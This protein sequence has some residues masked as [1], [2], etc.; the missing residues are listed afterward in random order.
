MAVTPPATAAAEG[1][2]VD[3]TNAYSG[4]E[5]YRGADSNDLPSTYYDAGTPKMAG[6]AAMAG[7]AVDPAMK[8]PWW[9]RKLVLGILAAVAVAVVVAVVVGAVVGTRK[10]ENTKSAGASSGASSGATT[11][12]NSTAAMKFSADTALAATGSG[13]LFYQAETGH[14]VMHDFNAKNDTVLN[15][16]VAPKNGTSLACVEWDNGNQLRLYYLS[17]DNI[18]QEYAWK[19]D[20]WS[21]GK[22]AQLAFQAR[23]ES[24][25][26]ALRFVSTNELRLYYQLSNST[27]QELSYNLNATNNGAQWD[28]LPQGSQMPQALAGTGLAAGNLGS[29]NG[30]RLYV[31]MQDYTLHEWCWGLTLNGGPVTTHWMECTLMGQVLAKKPRP[32]ARTPLAAGF[33]DV[34][35]TPEIKLIYQTDDGNIVDATWQDNKNWVEEPFP[36]G[37]AGTVSKSGKM[38]VMVSNGPNQLGTAYYMADDGVREMTWQIPGGQWNDTNQGVVVMANAA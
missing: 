17:P 10:E 21:V 9:K 37:S 8:R 26:A 16:G 19:K 3:T 25:L 12:A 11:S 30:L 1:L 4:L 15:V 13:K 33:W 31:Q 29:G 6:E 2:E 22:L 38:A 24:Q 7:G 27:L 5:V 36:M 35:D 34:N 32:K 20:S 28:L 23:S 18:I 14:L